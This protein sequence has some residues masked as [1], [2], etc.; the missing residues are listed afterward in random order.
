M[1]KRLSQNEQTSGATPSAAS[2][3]ARARERPRPRVR[4]RPLAQDDARPQLIVD[5]ATRVD[6]RRRHLMTCFGRA[7]R[8]KIFATWRALRV[9]IFA[10]SHNDTRR[11]RRR[12]SVKYDGESK[13]AR[14]LN[15]EL[16]VARLRARARGHFDECRPS[17]RVGAASHTHIERAAVRAESESTFPCTFALTAACI[18]FSRRFADKKA[19]KSCL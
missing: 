10:K 6:R 18:D 9:E 5:V 12:R 7:H 16:Q 15:F 1:N 17:A 11:W 3:R 2:A 13:R 14:H 19:D 4:R 8:L